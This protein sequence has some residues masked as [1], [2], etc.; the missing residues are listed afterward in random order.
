MGSLHAAFTCGGAVCAAEPV[1]ATLG[2]LAG[3]A[4][5]WLHVEKMLWR[6]EQVKHLSL[7]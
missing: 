1:D 6:I 5:E 2:S 3:D 4:A 7:L